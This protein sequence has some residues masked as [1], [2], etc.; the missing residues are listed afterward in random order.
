M[1][2]T[3]RVLEVPKTVRNFATSNTSALCS[4]PCC[5]GCTCH[6]TT[7]MLGGCDVYVV[8]CGG[9]AAADADR[10]CAC[11]RMKA[12]NDTEMLHLQEVHHDE[13]MRRMQSVF[14]FSVVW[15][16]H[17]AAAVL[18][19][20]ATVRL[21][22]ALCSR[23]KWLKRLHRGLT[24]GRSPLHHRSSRDAAF[25][26]SLLQLGLD[27]T[28]G[29]LLPWEQVARCGAAVPS[30]LTHRVPP[31]LHSPV[32]MAAHAL[33]IG[34][35][36]EQAVQSSDQD[37]P[38]SDTG[39]PKSTSSRKTGSKS[40]QNADGPARGTTW[41]SAKAAKDAPDS[42]LWKPIPMVAHGLD[43]GA[44]GGSRSFAQEGAA[45]SESPA[46]AGDPHGYRWRG[47]GWAWCQWLFAGGD[48]NDSSAAFQC[49]V[50]LLCCLYSCRTPCGRT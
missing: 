22:A 30:A 16:L 25:Q 2:W 11:R 17:S 38:T 39:A 27:T 7:R 40:T 44:D 29:R 13:V 47:G 14:V 3:T 41:A 8:S 33:A 34:R 50:C 43:A 45:P 49:V 9:G 36:W 35:R 37:T 12:K 28:R 5:G 20:E 24:T 42:V 32:T 18:G 6:R 31:S 1:L 10:G 19:R 4:D 48:A 23:F 21:D 26:A 15:G 46:T